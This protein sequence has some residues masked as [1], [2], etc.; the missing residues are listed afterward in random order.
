MIRE[1]FD[2]EEERSGKVLLKV[3]GVRVGRRRDADG[4][5]GRVEDDGREGF[6][7]ISES[8]SKPGG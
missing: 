3:A 7:G 5:Q 8:S 2:I 6:N 1:R 4:R